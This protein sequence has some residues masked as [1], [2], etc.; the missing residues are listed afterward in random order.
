VY[1]AKKSSCR[2]RACSG[3]GAHVCSRMLT[4]AHVCSCM[5][6]SEGEFVQEQGVC[7]AGAQ[8]TSALLALLVPKVQI[9]V[10]EGEFVQGQ[11]EGVLSLLALIV[12]QY[13][14]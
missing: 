11:G 12:Q 13:K 14:Y 6:T 9:Q 10:S 3:A 5:L 8:F 7:G 4:Y 2:S 1:A